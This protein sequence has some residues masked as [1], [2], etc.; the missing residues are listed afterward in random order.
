MVTF[1]SYIINISK[2]YLVTCKQNLE[3][4]S[5]CPYSSCIGAWSGLVISV[6]STGAFSPQQQKAY[7]SPARHEIFA[8]LCFAEKAGYP[9]LRGQGRR[10]ERG[11]A[12]EHVSQ[13]EEGCQGTDR[14]HTM[15]SN[16]PPIQCTTQCHSCAT[17]ITVHLRAS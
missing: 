13:A 8:T 7:N 2:E 4:K 10:L 15:F 9:C 6:L 1:M 3:F 16:H 5:Q 12:Q 14:T 11:R 17:V